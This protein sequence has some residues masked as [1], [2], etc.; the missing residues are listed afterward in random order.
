MKILMRIHES[1]CKLFAEYYGLFFAAGILSCLFSV[2]PIGIG[3]SP[4]T[5]PEYSLLTWKTGCLLYGFVNLITTFVA[6]VNISPDEYET[7]IDWEGRFSELLKP[8]IIFFPLLLI[9][10]GFILATCVCFWTFMRIYKMYKR[11]EKVIFKW[12][13]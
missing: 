7:N 5:E 2:W 1:L 11:V 9:L 13:S 12:H 3:I 8:L 6:L 10:W 4:M